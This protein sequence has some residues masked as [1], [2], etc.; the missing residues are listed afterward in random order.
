MI[1]NELS[2]LLSKVKTERELQKVFSNEMAAHIEVS[3]KTYNRIE[4]LESDLS[5]KHFLLICKKLKRKPE[6]FF[7]GGNS[8]FFNDCHNSG[9]NNTYNIVDNSEEIK[10][11][12]EA[13]TQLVAKNTSTK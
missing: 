2:T 13:L 7:D 5:M 6:Y 3:E 11:I 8:V 1:K 12:T 4:K 10:K 9:V